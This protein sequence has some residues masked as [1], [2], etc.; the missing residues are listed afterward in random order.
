MADPSDGAGY[1]KMREEYEVHTALNQEINDGRVWLRSAARERALKNRRCVVRISAPVA[2]KRVYC[3]A[4]YADN[5]YLEEWKKRGR[6]FFQDKTKKLAFISA[7]HRTPLG[8]GLGS[9]QLDVE[10]RRSSRPLWW[11]IRACIEHPQIVVCLATVLGIIG[12]GLGILGVGLSLL[13][14]TEWQPYARWGGAVLATLGILVTAL[15]L[16]L[17][18]A[19][20]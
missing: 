6:D 11:Q 7:W 3:E 8:I 19:R 15:P 20:Q 10:I 9:H 12:V 1:G 5:F 16:V 17:V 13:G 4:L 2:K 18:R 14:I